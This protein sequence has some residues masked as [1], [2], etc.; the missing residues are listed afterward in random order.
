MPSSSSQMLGFH[1][2]RG[3]SVPKLSAPAGD[4]LVQRVFK[5]DP[6]QAIAEV[7]R[8]LLARACPRL[9]DIRSFAEDFQ[10]QATKQSTRGVEG[11]MR[12]VV[13]KRPDFEGDSECAPT[14]M[15]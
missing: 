13:G 10:G 15:R 12:C 1:V 9:V 11:E 5:E 6:L 4:D 7:A 8:K 14:G 3:V 2:Q